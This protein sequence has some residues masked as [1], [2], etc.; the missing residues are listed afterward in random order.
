MIIGLILFL[1]PKSAKAF[2]IDWNLPKRQGFTFEVGLAEGLTQSFQTPDGNYI[3][4][5]S[6]VGFAPPQLSLGW[7]VDED[8]ALMIRE[9]GT[10]YYDWDNA[11]N[12]ELETFTGSY[13][14][15]FGNHLFVGV[16]AGLGTYSND[17]FDFGPYA[18]KYGI[19]F[20]E[21]IGL[22]M[23]S[24]RHISLALTLDL[25]QVD[26]STPNNQPETFVGGESI[27][28]QIQYY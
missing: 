24:E 28:L 26:F 2:D 12:K 17:P 10:G 6:K 11:T 21:R 22:S 23:I 14:H 4:H 19:G 7:F 27:G 9:V 20:N 15:W 18:T 1:A 25:I 5:V 8:N 3:H 16:G 13:Q